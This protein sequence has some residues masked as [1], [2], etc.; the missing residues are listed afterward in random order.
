M[1][2]TEVVI[3]WLTT[4]CLQAIDPE[5]LAM[6]PGETF[7]LGNSSLDLSPCY[8]LYFHGVVMLQSSPLRGQ[9]SSS[10]PGFCHPSSLPVSKDP[11]SPCGRLLTL[12]GKI[13][14]SIP[15]L[16][17][18]SFFLVQ[19]LF[20]ERLEKNHSCIIQVLCN[21]D[22]KQIIQYCLKDYSGKIILLECCILITFNSVLIPF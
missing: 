8:C 1:F 22:S 3:E 11:S 16:N 15:S 7:Y 10:D 6:I 12:R 9:L 2:V 20:G 4:C 21:S 13:S 19:I 17:N 14:Y 18:L 5:P